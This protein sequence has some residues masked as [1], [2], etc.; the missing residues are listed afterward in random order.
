MK[1]KSIFRTHL[2][3]LVLSLATISCTDEKVRVNSVEA[4]FD[5]LVDR[6]DVPGTIVTVDGAMYYRVANLSEKRLAHIKLDL[7]ADENYYISTPVPG[8]I[9]I[10]CADGRICPCQSGANNQ[11]FYFITPHYSI[12]DNNAEHSSVDTPSDERLFTNMSIFINNEDKF[13]TRDTI[14]V[15]GK[16]Y[17]RYTID[18]S[19]YPSPLVTRLKIYFE[20]PGSNSEEPPKECGFKY[21]KNKGMHHGIEISPI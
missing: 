15:N 4:M 11:V 21:D 9:M 20:L 3:F 17:D 2:F 5:K 6:P 13:L 8:E 10:I 7:E 16:S 19:D 14:F 18:V 12:L 1:A